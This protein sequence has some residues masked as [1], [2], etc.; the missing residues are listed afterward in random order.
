MM[1]G[2]FRQP[3]EDYVY[4]THAGL[5]FLT[6]QEFRHWRRLSKAE[7]DLAYFF[8]VKLVE[9]EEAERAALAFAG[10]KLAAFPCPPIPVAE[11]H[12][13]WIHR[14][15]SPFRTGNAR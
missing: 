12:R 9:D 10:G 8:M 14:N 3:D 4:V 2:F 13:F 7:R 15:R 6:E 1:G 11:R 5:A